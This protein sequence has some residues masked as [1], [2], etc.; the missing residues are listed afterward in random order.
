MNAA[1]LSV[2]LILFLFSVVK[3]NAAKPVDKLECKQL[4]ESNKMLAQQLNQSKQCK[5]KLKSR[6]CSYRAGDT[7]IDI[8][9][10]NDIL[11]A[12]KSKKTSAKSLD[13]LVIVH[14]LDSR[15]RVT[16]FPK[17]WPGSVDIVLKKQHS[18]CIY[19]NARIYLNR[20][21]WLSKW[22]QSK[23]FHLLRTGKK[24]P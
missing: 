16:T 8:K 4:R 13:L 2:V 15:M 18:Q 10:T 17:L 20:V 6:T 22:Y 21:S 7:H 5:Q 3:L 24:D 12:E 11:N 14:A 23:Y 9:F 1:R 19:G